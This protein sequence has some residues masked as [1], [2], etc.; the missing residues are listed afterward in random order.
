MRIE[1]DGIGFFPKLQLQLHTTTSTASP[2][3]IGKVFKVVSLEIKF[4]TDNWCNYR[5]SEKRELGE[6]TVQCSLLLC[7]VASKNRFISY[8][9][10]SYEIITGQV[11]K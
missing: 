10:A 8:N 1:W 11:N 9:F 7:Y 2:S 6:R 4:A 5:R 3:A